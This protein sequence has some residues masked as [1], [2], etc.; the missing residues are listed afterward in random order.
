[1]RGKHQTHTDVSFCFSIVLSFPSNFS[2]IVSS[3]RTEN[4]GQT[5]TEAEFSNTSNIFKKF[6]LFKI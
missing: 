5:G 2:A 1:M 6:R 4:T 3:S